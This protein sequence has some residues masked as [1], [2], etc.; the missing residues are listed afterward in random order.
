MFKEIF[1]KF[2]KIKILKTILETF[3]K[4]RKQFKEKPS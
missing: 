4:D 2:P 1:A 3:K